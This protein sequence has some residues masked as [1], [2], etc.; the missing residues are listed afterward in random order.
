[1]PPSVPPSRRSRSLCAS[2]LPTG[3]FRVQR[4]GMVL[5]GRFPNRSRYLGAQQA[6]GPRFWILF[7]NGEFGR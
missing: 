6:A 5:K 2:L 7:F 1:M 3:L 4:P